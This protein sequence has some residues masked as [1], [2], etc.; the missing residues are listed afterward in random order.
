MKLE[1]KGIVTAVKVLDE[2]SIAVLNDEGQ[3]LIFKNW[4]CNNKFILFY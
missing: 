2:N 3:L 1:C 4:I